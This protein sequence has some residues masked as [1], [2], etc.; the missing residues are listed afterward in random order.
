[1]SYAPRH[2]PTVGS[3]EEGVSYERG[4]PGAA[5]QGQAAVERIWH[6]RQTGLGVQVKVRETFQVVNSSLGGGGLSGFSFT[7]RVSG[8]RSRISGFESRVSGAGLVGSTRRK[9]SAIS[10]H[11][12]QSRPDSGPGFQVKVLKV[13]PSSLGRGRGGCRV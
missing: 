5:L 12:R 6:T 10:A 3:Q 7:F 9:F 4:T 8:F 11:I 2:R 13:V 1:M